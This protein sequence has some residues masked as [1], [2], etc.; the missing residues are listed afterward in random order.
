VVSFCRKQAFVILCMLVFSGMA[1]A[2]DATSPGTPRSDAPGTPGRSL[3]LGNSQLGLWAG[4][5]WTNPQLMG[6]TSD[7]PYVEVDVQY[8]RVV[9]TGDIWALKYIAELV[10]VAVVTQPQQ[11]SASASGTRQKVYGAGITPVGLQLNFRRGSVLQPF[12]NVTG[13]IIYFEDQVPVA[14]SSKFNFTLGLGAGVEVWHLENQSI[15][16]GYK[17]HHISN[18]YTARENPGVDSSLFYVGYTWSW[19]R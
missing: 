14:D 15:L 8:A 3:D 4:Y 12:V 2:Q 9:K 18:G 5:S 13:G 19:S 10:P 6:R 7:I 11:G 17:Y 1:M 16:L